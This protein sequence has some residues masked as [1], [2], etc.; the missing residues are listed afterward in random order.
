MSLLV[1]ARSVLLSV[2]RVSFEDLQRRKNDAPGA[3]RNCR[4]DPILIT[5]RDI[6][7]CPD[8]GL[9][10]Q[11]VLFSQDATSSPRRRCD[12]GR[13]AAGIES[14]GPLLRDGLQC[15]GEPESVDGVA[16]ADKGSVGCVDLA[17]ERVLR[18][19]WVL[20]GVEC[21]GEVFVDFE[22]V[23]S[24]LDRR[25]KANEPTCQIFAW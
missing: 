15:V 1:I 10:F 25:L 12:V 19:E 23:A 17:E 2:S 20:L 8:D 6:R 3:R 9:V 5:V 24:E 4:E 7:R 11:Q 22:A 21:G 14:V 18:N 13:N 16:L